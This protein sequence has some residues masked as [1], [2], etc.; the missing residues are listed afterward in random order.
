V[1]RGSFHRDAIGGRRSI[2]GH[3]LTLG[4]GVDKLPE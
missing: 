2:D 4:A 3:E 1:P